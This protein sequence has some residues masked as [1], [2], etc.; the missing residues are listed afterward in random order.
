MYNPKNGDLLH[1][2]DT[3][4]HSNAKGGAYDDVRLVKK[5]EYA[6][7]SMCVVCDIN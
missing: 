3:D 2:N 4:P 6:S 5:Y 7:T 1:V